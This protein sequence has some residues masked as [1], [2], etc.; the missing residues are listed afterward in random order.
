MIGLT[1]SG[2]GFRKTGVAQLINRLFEGRKKRK[3][4]EKGEE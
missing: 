1:P 4:E 3:I 2:N